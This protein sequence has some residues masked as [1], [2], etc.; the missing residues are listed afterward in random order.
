MFVGL[1]IDQREGEAEKRSR[2]KEEII[3]EQ[4]KSKMPAPP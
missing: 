2:M 1:Q 3:R 4:L